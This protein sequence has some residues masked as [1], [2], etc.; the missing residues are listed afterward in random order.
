MNR[1]PATAHTPRRRAVGP[2]AHGERHARAHGMLA[3]G[4]C[5]PGAA[6]VVFRAQAELDARAHGMLVDISCGTGAAG[7]V[8]CARP[9]QGGALLAVK[10]YTR[11]D[12]GVSAAK[13]TAAL[14]A[15]GDIDG[16]AGFRG[17]FSVGG[18]HYVVMGL[19]HGEELYG[20][21]ERHGALQEREARALAAAILRALAAVHARGW[22]H[23]DV[24]PENIIWD[25]VAKAAV[26]V[27][28]GFAAR[29]GPAPAA[30]GTRE[31]LAPEIRAGAM[32]DTQSADI[33]AA[34]ATLFV[35]VCGLFP[36]TEGESH[37]RLPR[38]PRGMP[39]GAR[40]LCK[41]MMAP[42][43]AQRPGAETLLQAPWLARCASARPP[44]GPAPPAPLDA[45][46]AGFGPGPLAPPAGG[47]D[48]GSDGGVSNVATCGGGTT[49]APRAQGAR[50]DNR[51]PRNARSARGVVHEGV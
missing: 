16:I 11:P 10:R 19:A 29:A 34:G 41:A 7:E 48:A 5:D 4:S 18:R 13:E 12:A 50:A 15:L 32:W 6:G 49:L 46:N 47:D 1:A 33:F 17:A 43:P 23:N 9:V 36:Y 26:L 22:A 45:V 14:R 28:L 35:A 27:D 31:Y 21:V 25:A 51:A 37:A 30:V 8:F 38:F 2:D 3:D 40:A 42:D 20:V 44:R 24:K 39:S